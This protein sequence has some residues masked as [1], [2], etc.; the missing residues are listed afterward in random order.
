M[1]DMSFRSPPA[2][3]AWR[4]LD[5][6]NGF[7][8]VYFRSGDGHLMQGC[9][10]AVEDGEPWIVDYTVE[11]DDSW[12][13]RRVSVTRRGPSGPD[14]VR[15]ESD[16]NGRWWVNDEHAPHLDGCL[17][18]DL[19]SS[20]MTNALPAHRMGLP[21]GGQ[22][23]APAAYVRV[24]EMRVERLEQT[25]LRA[26]DADGRQQYNYAAPAFEVECRLVYDRSGLVLDYPGL[27][28][29]AS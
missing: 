24:G 8:V 27:A 4:H 18:V 23:E 9:T 2:S 14:E 22:A 16:G 1:T 10:T 6:R 3:A 11:V 7:E 25:Y 12:L 19:E 17:D 28:V 29:R 21:V 15:L 26:P 5:A 20:V 13:T